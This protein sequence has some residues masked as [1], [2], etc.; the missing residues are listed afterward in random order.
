M[1]KLVLSTVGDLHL[2]YLEEDLNELLVIRDNGKAITIKQ[3]SFKYL[4]DHLL[5]CV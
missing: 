2:S 1:L 3:R 5:C 4:I